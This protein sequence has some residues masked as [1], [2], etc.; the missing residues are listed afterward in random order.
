MSTTTH[1]YKTDLIDLLQNFDTN[2]PDLREKVLSLI[3]AWDLLRDLGAATI[4][5]EITRSARGRILHYF[6]QYPRT[7]ISNRE[8]MIISGISEWARRVRELRQDFGWTI[9]NGLAIQEMIEAGDLPQDNDLADCASMTKDDYIMLENEQDREAAHRWKVAN[10]IRKGSGGAQSKILAFLLENV[11]N[12]V[13]GEELRYVTKNKTE[14]ARR[15]RELR[16]EEGWQVCTHRN[17][18]PDLPPGMYVLESDRQLPVH[19]RKIDDQVRRAVLIRDNHTC[20]KCGW[21]HEKWNPSDPRHLEL[22][23]IEHHA[24]GGKNTEENL[25]TLCNICHDLEHKKK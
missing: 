24:K 12:P 25:L 5:Q 19:D 16:T 21:I 3:P 13:S 18:R 6:Q 8:I 20:Q 14:W 1:Q 11:G 23:H 15:T 10:D 22:H 9:I 4:P 2:S 7:I 17:G